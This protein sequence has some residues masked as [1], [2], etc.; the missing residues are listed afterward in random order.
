[1]TWVFSEKGG[2]VAAGNTTEL[3][4]LKKLGFVECGKP[5]LHK[6]I[7]ACINPEPI[8]MESKHLPGCVSKEELIDLAHASGIAIDK[9]WSVSR[10]MEALGL[11][12]AD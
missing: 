1:M 10:I 4:Q 3:E 7:S 5:S 6:M 8:V 2:Y 12:D 11:S 9:R